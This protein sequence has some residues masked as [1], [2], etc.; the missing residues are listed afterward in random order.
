[1]ETLEAALARGASR[2]L[3][4]VEVVPHAKSN[5]SQCKGQ[6][7]QTRIMHAGSKGEVRHA[8]P[9]PCALKRFKK[10]HDADVH[11]VNNQ[12]VWRQGRAPPLPPQRG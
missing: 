12:I 6:G 3:F 5:C 9:C 8:V 11:T 10:I 7:Y 1:M 4:I 2:P